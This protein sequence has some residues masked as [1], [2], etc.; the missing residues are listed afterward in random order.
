VYAA[1]AGGQA[2]PSRGV[3][4]IVPYPAGGTTDAIA[5]MVVEKLNARWGQPV[6]VENRG[7]AAGNIGA[8]LVARAEPDGYTLLCAAPGPIAVND[9]MY[10]KLGY[11]P[12]KF[13]PVSVLAS[14]PN[15]LVVRPDFPSQSVQE[16]VALAK[17]NPE[18]IAYASQ[19]SGSTSHLTT[20]LFQSMAE[21]RLLHVPY[22]G[23]APA[24]TDLMGGQ[25][26]LMF[27]NITSSLAP[28]RAGRIRVLAVA[29]P[30]RLPLLPAV[31]TMIEQGFAGFESGTWVAI[32][33]PP[34][35]PEALAAQLGQA[36][37]EAVRQ[38]D[39]RRKMQDLAALPVGNAPAEAAVH[40]AA[41]RARWRRVI[42]AASVTLE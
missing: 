11:D 21:I 13:V 12:A 4:V 28:A 42:Q 32:V 1:A 33:A 23:T 9:S 31:P 5:R 6:V 40:I 25:V 36:M 3:R 38:P 30:Q 16:L 27:D 8:E 2:F 24:L 14:M 22:K 15:V 35:T 18:R 29:S 10:R 41:E 34:G 7:G 37:S 39:V 17:A 19:G 20:A 26:D